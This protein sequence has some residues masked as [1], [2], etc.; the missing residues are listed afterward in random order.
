M[1]ELHCEF[2]FAPTS[3]LNKLEASEWYFDYEDDVEDFYTNVENLEGFIG[4]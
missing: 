1:E 3:E 2:V 4:E